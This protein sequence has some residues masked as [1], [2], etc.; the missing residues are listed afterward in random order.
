MHDEVSEQSGQE[1]REQ[2]ERCRARERQCDRQA[3]AGELAHLTGGD[4]RA[5]RHLLLARAIGRLD[6]HVSAGEES[7]VLREVQVS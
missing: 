5:A 1:A 2:R 3:G 7:A 6:E 4:K